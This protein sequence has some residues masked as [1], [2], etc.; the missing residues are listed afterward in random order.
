MRRPWL[1]PLAEGVGSLALLMI[2]LAAIY[3]LVGVVPGPLMI[4]VLGL[5]FGGEPLRQAGAAWIAE[6]REPAAQLPSVTMAV[7]L[8][9]MIEQYGQANTR[10]AVLEVLHRRA[11]ARGDHHDAE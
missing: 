11:L 8:E 10:R 1:P 7:E 9:P 4:T 3:D 2:G 6:R 5:L